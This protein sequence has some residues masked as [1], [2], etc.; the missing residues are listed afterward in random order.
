MTSALTFIQFDGAIREIDA[1]DGHSLMEV[2]D[3]QC[4][5]VGMAIAAAARACATCH[6]H[7]AGRPV[8]TGRRSETESDTRSRPSNLGPGSRLACQIK[9][10]PALAGLTVH[11]PESQ[12]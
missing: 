9:V 11:L 6:V 2:A 7:I 1:E 4:G 3:P 8:R 12:H 10:E 5:I